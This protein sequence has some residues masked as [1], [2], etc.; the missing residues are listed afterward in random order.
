MPEVSIDEDLCIGSAACVNLAPAA[1]AL[2]DRRV[3][4]PAD[5]DAVP[6]EVLERAARL[7]PAAAITV[8]ESV[9]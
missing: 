1:F 9:R 7:C 4:S 5:V 3:A 6:T 2:D 8:T